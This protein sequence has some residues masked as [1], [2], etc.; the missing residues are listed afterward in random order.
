[1]KYFHMVFYV[2]HAFLHN[3][4]ILAVITNAVTFFRWID[5]RHAGVQFNLF[6]MLRTPIS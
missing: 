4:Y 5:L 2:L 3:F 1:M 6:E